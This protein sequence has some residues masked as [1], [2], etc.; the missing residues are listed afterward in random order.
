MKF[1]RTPLLFAVLCLFAAL[2]ASALTVRNETGITV[3]ATLDEVL[4]P[5]VQGSSMKPGGTWS[6][7]ASPQAQY[8][9]SFTQ[10]DR[11]L[12]DTLLLGSVQTAALVQTPDGYRILLDRTTGSA[13]AAAPAGCIRGKVIGNVF[14]CLSF[15]TEDGRTLTLTGNTKGLPLIGDAC[16]CGT[17]IGKAGPCLFPAFN[18]EK[19]CDAPAGDAASATY[20]MVVRNMTNTPVRVSIQHPPAMVVFSRDIAANGQI[21]LT[22]SP[23][24]LFSLG[25]FRGDTFLAR[26][27]VRNAAV[28]AL[29][30]SGS[31]YIIGIAWRQTPETQALYGPPVDATSSVT[32]P[33]FHCWSGEAIGYIRLSRAFSSGGNTFY[34]SGNVEDVPVLGKAC[35]C[36]RLRPPMKGVLIPLPI[37]DVS[38]LCAVGEER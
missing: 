25:F 4:A 6:P 1:T 18:V 38:S 34:L 37:I 10:N 7:V 12:A 23:A 8:R 28:V 27:N 2:D 30:Q 15:N 14:G 17:E 16:I 31:G 36:G 5:A 29:E 13:A 35:V 22:A 11:L 33:E 24:Q 26:A 9:L 20:Q 3:E 21:T 19:R 32:E